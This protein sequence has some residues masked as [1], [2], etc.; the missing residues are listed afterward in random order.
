MAKTI[1]LSTKVVMYQELLCMSTPMESIFPLKLILFFY[2]FL[3]IGSPS[4]CLYL[5]LH[6]WVD[7]AG[8][9]IHPGDRDVKWDQIEHIRVG[10]G[11]AFIHLTI[12]DDQPIHL[13]RHLKNSRQFNS[14]IIKYAGSILLEKAIKRLRAEHAL[15]ACIDLIHSV[16][17]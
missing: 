14:V 8:I 5:R 16:Y 9:R 17:A 12:R 2:T 4:F 15:R 1:F 6:V 13:S 7:A 3:V 11:I 10:V